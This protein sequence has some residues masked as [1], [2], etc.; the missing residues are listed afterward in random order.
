MEISASVAE[1]ELAHSRMKFPALNV[2][3]HSVPIHFSSL[4]KT[5]V[6][7]DLRN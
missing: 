1:N 7:R 5:P 4:R 6:P 3:A 2:P